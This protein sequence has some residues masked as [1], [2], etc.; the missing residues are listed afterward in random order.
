[1]EA[2]LTDEKTLAIDRRMG[3]PPLGM[4]EIKVQFPAEMLEKV[5]ALVGD[6]NRSKFIRAAVEGALA[7]AAQVKSPSNSEDK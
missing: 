4:K 3:R 7:T 1:M 5:D 2:A 6:K